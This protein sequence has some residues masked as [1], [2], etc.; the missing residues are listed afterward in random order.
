MLQFR[1][2][3]IE[4]KKRNHCEFSRVYIEI[5]EMGR[6]PRSWVRSWEVR[7]DAALISIS[8][9]PIYRGSKGDQSASAVAINVII[10]NGAHK[11]LDRLEVSPFFR[12]LPFSRHVSSRDTLA[13][14]DAI[15]PNDA[16][17]L[18]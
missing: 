4:I 6:Q 7:S 2:I 10:F 17:W 14:R 18:A 12:S 5:L 13:Q 8:E 9:Y 1:S 3:P 15:R 11:G 16:A